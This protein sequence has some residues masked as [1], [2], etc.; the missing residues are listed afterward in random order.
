MS[1]IMLFSRIERLDNGVNVIH[2]NFMTGEESKTF[3]NTIDIEGVANA[4]SDTTLSRSLEKFLSSYKQDAFFSG[5]DKK[6]KT[7]KDERGVK[8]DKTKDH[9]FS[10]KL[11]VYRCRTDESPEFLLYDGKTLKE[12]DRVYDRFYKNPE[13]I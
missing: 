8:Y 11:T 1:N 9:V 12:V 2:K 7:I 6:K 4:T 10:E 5:L 3:V 13:N